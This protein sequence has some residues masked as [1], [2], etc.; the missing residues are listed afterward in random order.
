[1]FQHSLGTPLGR[2]SIMNLCVRTHTYTNTLVY[3]HVHTLTHT[4]TRIHK[5]TRTNTP[6]V[7][8]DPPVAE[9][10]R[11]D[12]GPIILNNVTGQNWVRSG[13]DQV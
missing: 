5:H 13:S 9:Y 1:M 6:E 11:S 8:T 10:P 4:H 7:F 2:Q 3:T 12:P